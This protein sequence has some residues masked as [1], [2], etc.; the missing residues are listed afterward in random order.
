LFGPVP[1][2]AAASGYAFVYAIEI[3][4]LIATVWVMR[5]L[6]GSTTPA[7]GGAAFARGAPSSNPS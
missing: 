1:W 2:P 5:P 3:V 4:L 6:V 7:F